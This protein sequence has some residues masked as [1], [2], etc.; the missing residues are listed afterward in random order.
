MSRDDDFTRDAAGDEFRAAAD[1]I[2]SADGGISD[3]EWIPEA[4]LAA[5][6][7]EQQVHPDESSEAMTRRLFRENSA[8][9]TASIVHI[10]LHG[11]NERLRLDASKYVVER[12]LGRVGEDK[13]TDEEQPLD[14]LVR[15]M[16]MA[17]EAHA[18]RDK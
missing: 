4:S 15:Q 17:A 2:P 13:G 12:V 5:I 6:A 3:E 14:A 1:N 7:M 16:A 9:A 10:A 11:S 18:N 8:A